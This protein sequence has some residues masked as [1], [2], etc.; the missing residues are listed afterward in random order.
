MQSQLSMSLWETELKYSTGRNS[1]FLHFHKVIFSSTLTA[2]SRGV[3][4]QLIGVP[5]SQMSK[6]EHRVVKNF[7]ETTSELLQTQD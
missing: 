2:T 5:M 3:K 6:R 1:K 4:K 7:M